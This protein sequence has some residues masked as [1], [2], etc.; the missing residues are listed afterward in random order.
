MQAPSPK[1]EMMQCLSRTGTGGFKRGS[2]G[3]ATPTAQLYLNILGAL[4]SSHIKASTGIIP[5]RLIAAIAAIGIGNPVLQQR[6]KRHQAKVRQSASSQDKESAMLS[7]IPPVQVRAEVC[8]ALPSSHLAFVPKRE[9][10]TFLL[11]SS[12]STPN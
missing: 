3:C 11:P 9:S 5:P 8:L 7:L 6:H 2:L 12:C 1:C 10:N 4:I